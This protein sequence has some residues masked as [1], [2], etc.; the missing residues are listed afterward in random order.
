ML[1]VKRQ[2]KCWFEFYLSYLL[3]EI[4][5]TLCKTHI[6]MEKRT[7]WW[8][9]WR[10]DKSRKA[11]QRSS[12]QSSHFNNEEARCKESKQ[13]AQGHMIGDYI[14]NFPA[15]T[16]SQ[17]WPTISHLLINVQV[18]EHTDLQKQTLWEVESKILWIQEVPQMIQILNIQ[19]LMIMKPWC[20]LSMAIG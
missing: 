11:P 4:G 10:Y 16:N 7:G 14:H 15:L 9:K 2:L 18:P 1:A 13:P 19:R 17:T 20:T 3:Y 6:R 5:E 8:M 12:F